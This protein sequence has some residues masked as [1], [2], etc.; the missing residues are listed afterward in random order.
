MTWPPLVSIII[1]SH[2]GTVHEALRSAVEQTCRRREVLVNFCDDWSIDKVNGLL[3]AASG[4]YT[5]ILCDDDLLLPDY[6][7]R[8]L[9]L[10]ER[11]NADVIVPDVRVQRRVG[12]AW[13]D[14]H[15]VQLGPFTE[16]KFR[17][18]VRGQ[19]NCAPYITSLVRTEL[20]LQLGGWDGDQIHYDFA[21]FYGLLKRGAR[22]ERLARP[23]W[24]YREGPQQGTRG[25]DREEA[26]RR[27][28]AK[29]PE[30]AA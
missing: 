11:T 8:A 25:V 15:V 3:E 2:R 24:I 1:P 28:V 23:T 13:V 20:L 12:A 9:E 16:Q 30:L 6:V 22:F 17:G 26:V 27:M 5:T 14:S 21:M 18:Y 29:Y 7:E 19:S 4:R 10:A